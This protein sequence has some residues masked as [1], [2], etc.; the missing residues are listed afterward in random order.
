[1]EEGLTFSRHRE[2]GICAY[3]CRARAGSSSPLAAGATRA[4]QGGD[5]G[6]EHRLNE[7]Y[8]AIRVIFLFLLRA[9]AR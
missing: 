6:W 3:L 4:R 2:C 7:A 1:M 8:E 9:M 5:S